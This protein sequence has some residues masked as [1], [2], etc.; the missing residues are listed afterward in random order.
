M[1]IYRTI[2]ITALERRVTTDKVAQILTGMGAVLGPDFECLGIPSISISDFSQPDDKPFDFTP[3][4]GRLAFGGKMNSSDIALFP[5]GPVRITLVRWGAKPEECGKIMVG[6]TDVHHTSMVSY[7]GITIGDYV[8]LDPRVVI[9]DSGGHP[10]DRRL[11]DNT[12][13][14]KTAP[15][16]IEDHAWIGYG[17]TIMPGVTVGHHAVVSPGSV[18]LWDVAPYAT[19]VGNPAKNAKVYRKHFEGQGEVTE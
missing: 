1:A 4:K 7:S 11:E 2:D 6:K 8:H 13:N 12:A 3:F 5:A 18:V 16:T 10:A 9:M 19:V 17:S 14:R 15:I